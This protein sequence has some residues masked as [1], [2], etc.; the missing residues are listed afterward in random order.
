MEAK[1]RLIIPL[2]VATR[3]EAEALVLRL[4]PQVGLFKIGLQLFHSEGPGVIEAVQKIAGPVFYDGKFYDIPNTVAGA[5]A[6]ITRLGVKMFNV[7]TLGGKAMMLAAREAAE[8]TAAAQGSVRPLVLGVTIV[9]SI[10]ETVL[11]EECGIG[12]PLEE[13]VLSLARLAQEAGLDGVVAS[14]HE[15][16]AIREACGKD[17]LIIC[18][19]IRPA[20]AAANDQARLATPQ[21]ARDS[22]AD[23]IVVGRPITGAPEPEKVAQTIVA[24]LGSGEK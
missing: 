11:L 23:Y 5:A 22:G 20:G 6:A 18:P 16:P 17:F 8:C 7:H 4:A 24:Q 21:L 10:D 14:V 1:D 13:E 3:E 15:A 19:G 12:R 2:D 9:T